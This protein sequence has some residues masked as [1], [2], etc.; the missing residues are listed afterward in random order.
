MSQHSLRVQPSSPSIPT[1]TTLVALTQMS[2][3]PNQARYK[4]MICSL[5]KNRT[6]TLSREYCILYT[7]YSIL[8]RLELVKG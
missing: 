2:T 8:I 6:L 3:K 7:E 5:L 4:N 1:M